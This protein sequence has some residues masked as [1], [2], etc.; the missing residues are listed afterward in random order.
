MPPKQNKKQG[1]NQPQNKKQNK[2]IKNPSPKTQNQKKPTEKQE[3]NGSSKE[4]NS[5]FIKVGDRDVPLRTASAPPDLNK[6]HQP[7]K[8]NTGLSTNFQPFVP[9]GFVP[10]AQPFIPKNIQNFQPTV[11]VPIQTNPV[12]K[13]APAPKKG[14]LI[15]DP[16]TGA[17]VDIFGNRIKTT[18]EEVKPEVEV[19]VEEKKEE[20]KEAKP[21]VEVK[22]QPV[23]V[24]ETKVEEEEE[25]EDSLDVE[26]EDSLDV[27]ISDKDDSNEEEEDSEEED[28][29]EEDDST[30][31][32]EEGDMKKKRVYTRDQLLKFKF[33]ATEPPDVLKR[34]DIFVD[35]TKST[36]ASEF[37][38]SWQNKPGGKPFPTQRGKKPQ[39][40]GK[41]SGGK[42][43]RDKGPK[44]EKSVAL[45]MKIE[46]EKTI[47]EVKF[48]LNKLSENNY[49]SIKKDLLAVEVKDEEVA[50]VIN[51]IFETAINNSVFSGMYA[52][53][54]VDISQTEGTIYG[55]STDFKKILLNSCQTEFEKIPEARQ[56]YLDAKAANKYS[57]VELLEISGK[58][59]TRIIGNM[60]F[61][62]ELFKKKML[63]ALIMH[64]IIAKLLLN[65]ENPEE[66]QIEILCSL[67]TNI[68]KN[69]EEAVDSRDYMDVYFDK[70]LEI[71]AEK[72]TSSRIRFMILDLMDLRKIGYQKLQEP[73]K[74][75]KQAPTPVNTSNNK[76]YSNDRNSNK[77]SGGKGSQDFR[78]S[79]RNDR[80]ERMEQKKNQSLSKPAGRG[81]G[82][83]SPSSSPSPTTS[84]P[85]WEVKGNSKKSMGKGGRKG[86]QTVYGN[87][88]QNDLIDIDSSNSFSAL[89]D[90]DN[91][92]PKSPTPIQIK[93]RPQQKEEMPKELIQTKTQSTFNSL[94][95]GGE[96]EDSMDD[97]KDLRLSDYS[98][99]V[100]T[101]IDFVIDKKDLERKLFVDLVVR[102]V[103]NNIFNESQLIKGVNL[104]IKS[105]IDTDLF[106]DVP[107]YFDWIGQII[108]RFVYSKTILVASFDKILNDEFL[109]SS[110]LVKVYSSIILTMKQEYELM[111]EQTIKSA[112][113][114]STTNFN[115]L[116]LLN[117]KKQFFDALLKSTTTNNTFDMDP[118]LF[119][120]YSI[121]QGKEA[122]K[123][124]KWFQDNLKDQ[125]GDGYL[126]R[127]MVSSFIQTIEMSSRFEKKQNLELEK[128]LFLKYS[129]ILKSIL[130][131]NENY[132]K[133]AILEIQRFSHLT[134]FNSGL[135]STLFD[136]FLNENLISKSIFENWLKD[137]KLGSQFEK[138]KAKEQTKEFFQKL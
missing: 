3:I 67:L 36:P 7:K 81:Y 133:I 40:G 46:K 47:S 33:L 54:C 136:L 62:G 32:E 93:R 132:Q 125:L 6:D 80:L 45:K 72:T 38:P 44:L 137:S 117:G 56:E 109:S 64:E 9:R 1:S 74:K 14:L 43:K 131:E 107:K 16:K 110:Q 112:K 2:D 122:E 12:P 124:T 75:T 92:S 78:K 85:E 86:Q 95:D 41:K 123:I 76:Y 10:T 15:I 22:P 58:L 128:E 24:E 134:N 20:K 111:N 127:Q 21:V 37:K 59:K 57:E 11:T 116:N 104:S 96:F 60:S 53:L 138:E 126:I 26:V 90:D 61:I 50:A 71:K 68:G 48:I 88:K 8:I 51:Q 102:C 129:S 100:A 73:K 113:Q 52:D 91:V 27:E 66:D 101:L 63:S 65:S 31:D 94:M 87:K 35:G 49:E 121:Q 99:S 79:S 108:G 114:I 77:K 13:P 82:G 4:E 118:V 89:D 97:L 130:S 28:S 83:Y 25:E 135:I 17:P 70:L 69:L 103:G 98:I 115:I 34:S 29:E 39:A 119:I 19:K 18:E 23:K 106:F 55:K 105:A 5:T 120:M 84:S 30:S 42:N